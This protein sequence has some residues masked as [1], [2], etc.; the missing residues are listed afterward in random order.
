ML[1]LP[2][3][4]FAA[5][6]KKNCLGFG[7]QAPLALQ[8]FSRCLLVWAKPKWRRCRQNKLDELNRAI[9]FNAHPALL[10]SK[11]A[12]P[13]LSLGSKNACVR[14]ETQKPRTLHMQSL[15]SANAKKHPKG[16]LAF[17][18]GGVC[19]KRQ[20]RSPQPLTSK[21]SAPYGNSRTPALLHSKSA[22]PAL[23]LESTN[24]K[25]HPIGVLALVD[26][27]RVELL[28][29][30]LFTGPSSWTVYDLAFPQDGEHRHPSPLGSP[31]LH[32]RYK[33]EL[34]VHVHHCMTPQPWSWSS[35]VG[36]A[37]FSRGT[38]D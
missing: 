22:S 26:P 3:E 29:E 11:S 31:F 7:E 16:V 32:D 21:L 28:S 36:R 6:G 24:A 34:S 33:C 37:A 4:G 13:A 14:A 27:R 38:A 17:T 8:Q 1:T 18:L 15:G 9:Q 23:S 35:S 25:K 10:H 5:S 19:R 20:K 2:S 12:S 30:N